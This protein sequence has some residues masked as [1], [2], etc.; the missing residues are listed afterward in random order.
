MSTY[1]RL[2]NKRCHSYVAAPLS[3]I[4]KFSPSLE[5]ISS[6]PVM[7]AGAGMAGAAGEGTATRT[8]TGSGATATTPS[9]GIAAPLKV[10]PGGA[11]L[12]TSSL[13]DCEGDMR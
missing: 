6:S 11:K 5:G 8:A 7:R 12:T 3:A 2:S 13:D 9:S 4:R 1:Q 10:V